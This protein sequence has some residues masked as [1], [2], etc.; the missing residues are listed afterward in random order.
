MRLF[1][2]YSLSGLF[3]S[4]PHLSPHVRMRQGRNTGHSIIRT[5]APTP[6]NST[7]RP[8]SHIKKLG[9]RY[10]R[11]AFGRFSLLAR[12]SSHRQRVIEVET[13]RRVLSHQSRQR[14]PAYLPVC[15]P[16]LPQ[17]ILDDKLGLVTVVHPVDRFS[18][19]GRLDRTNSAQTVVFYP[20][21]PFPNQRKELCL[22]CPCYTSSSYPISDFYR[23]F[24]V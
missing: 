6:R 17:C 14:S 13:Q 7:V 1:A 2:R 22:A 5:R 18:R 8:C 20:Q 23:C 10:T 4:M 21:I 19:L 15:T 16:G 12:R 9:G 24:R 11:R 3:R